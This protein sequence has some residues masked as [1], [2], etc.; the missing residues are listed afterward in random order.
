MTRRAALVRHPVA[1]AGIVLT[2]ISAGVFMAL[3]AA[4]AAGLLVNPY[5]GLVV[6]VALPA[7]FL[8]GLL[9]I[10]F[11]IWL[12]RR[13]LARR[14]LGEAVWPVIDLARPTVRR[15][16]MAVLVLSAINISILLT[17]GYG[18]LH[19]MESPQFC[20]QTCHTPMHPQFSA[21]SASSHSQ[22]ACATCHIGEGA[23][24]FAHAKLAGVRQLWHVTT[25]SYPRPIPAVASGM[26]R[27][28]EVCG[29]CHAATRNHGVLVRTLREYADDEMN[30]ESTTTL[31]MHVGG[32]GR[33]TL[34]DRSI[35]W[36]ASPNIRVEYLATDDDRQTIPYVKVSYGDGRMKEFTADGTTPQQLASAERR[37]MDC[38]DCHNAVGHRV[39]PTVESAVNAAI[40]E[41]QIGRQ[42]RFIRREAARL[43]SV[44]YPSQAAAED[45]IERGLRTFYR[46]GDVAALDVAALEQAVG[47][48]RAVYRHNVFPVMKVTW[49]TY[50]DN[51]GHVTSSGC[52]RCHDGRTAKDGSS[53]SAD[54]G[55]C[56]TQAE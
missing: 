53:I 41:G 16:V 3:V 17:A 34:S 51:I 11:G 32:P 27:A 13:R 7:A 23:Q 14:P 49:G 22:V 8:I 55:Y 52:F 25:S 2:T 56:H 6:F 5:A 12:E 36:H 29:R 28:S 33:P 4:M 19:W 15:T 20:G 45:A 40:A 54:C 10:L 21:W 48:L 24:S 35:H 9:L 26:P 1:L 38:I 18:A 50:P 30:T 39:A 43:L 31:Q 47:A 46:S 44:E 42:V 37:V